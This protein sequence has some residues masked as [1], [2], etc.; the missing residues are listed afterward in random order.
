MYYQLGLVFVCA[1][2]AAGG[3]IPAVIRLAR[4]KG[5]LDYP[6]AR[7]AHLTQTPTLGG[8]GIF[9]GFILSLTIFSSYDTN[10]H[11]LLGIIAG[12]I[13]LF[14]T[15]TKD[16]L[17]PLPPF[18]KLLAQLF[19]ISL[20]VFKG[21]VWLQGM[22]GL[23]GIDTLPLPVAYGLTFFVYVVIINAIN[24]V[25]GINGLAGSLVLAS[26][27]FLGVWFAAHDIQYLAVIS[28]SVAGS[29]AAF[30]YFNFRTH[31]QVF[32]GDTGSLILGF[33][34]SVLCIGF[35][36]H[37]HQLKSYAPGVAP[38][39]AMSILAIPLIDTVR[40]FLIRVINKRSPF[41]GDRNHLHHSLLRAGLNHLQASTFLLLFQLLVMSSMFFLPDSSLHIQLYALVVWGILLHLL[42]DFLEKRHLAIS[43]KTV[44]PPRQHKVKVKTE[45]SS[46][47]PAA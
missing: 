41:S 6:D 47:P 45:A 15:G 27:T 43:S 42:T 13:F 7:K 25:D 44:S 23:W 8:V 30:L 26:T 34:L 3:S 20:A 38:S 5:L 18:K 31:A 29:V 9:I 36:E 12:A 37:A 17:V 24:L 32:M 33:L 22:Y 28:F 39:I 46:Q 21:N 1:A 19:A 11:Q 35:I 4:E 16:D 2:F 10:G 14:F 40:V